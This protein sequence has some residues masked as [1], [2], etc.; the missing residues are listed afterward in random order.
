MVGQDFSPGI[1]QAQSIGLWI[2]F[3]N[4]QIDGMDKAGGEP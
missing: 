2:A 1:D 4:R 3:L